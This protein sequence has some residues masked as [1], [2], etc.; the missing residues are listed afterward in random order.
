MPMRADFT[1]TWRADLTASRLL[2]STPK[3]ILVAIAHSEPDLR[4]DMTIVTANDESTQIAF[5]ARST[6][7][8]IANTVLGG[9]WVSHSRW[10][11][12]ELLIESQVTQSGRHMHFRDYWS[13]SN[14]GR[15]LTMEHR[16]DDLAGQVTILDRVDFAGS[17]RD[18][19]AANFGSGQQ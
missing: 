2:G 13:L 19:P 16:D 18:R 5:A 17:S 7:Q 14:D 3:D 15:R 8:P 9:E 10:V 1:G 11:G 6:N 4:V 12:D